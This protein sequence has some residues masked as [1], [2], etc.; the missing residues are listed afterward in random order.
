M[1]SSQH[2]LV[3]TSVKV[4]RARFVHWTKPFTSSLA[5]GALADLGRSKAELVAENALLWQQLIILKRQVKR[6][7]CTKTDRILL[8]LE[9]SSG[10]DMEA[11]AFPCPARDAS[12]LAS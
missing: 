4:L 6:P 1:R 9:A 3:A 11:N 2:R 7:T 10:S 8:V 5:L 12:S